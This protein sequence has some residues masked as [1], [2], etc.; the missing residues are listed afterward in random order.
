MKFIE[1]RRE[2][3]Q[4]LDFKR[5]NRGSPELLCY[6]ALDRDTK[7]AVRLR[8]LEEQGY[9][10][11]YTMAGIGRGGVNDC[12]IEHIQ[13]QSGGDGSDLEY[14][15][16]VICA[17]SGQNREDSEW[18]AVRKGGAAV[19]RTN[20][21]TPLERDCERRLNYGVSG[22]V[23][24][25]NQADAAAR[26]AIDLLAL[27]HRFLIDARK[28]AL[29]LQGL[30]PDARRPLTAARAERLAQSITQP[31]R[32]GCFSPYC[33]AIKQTAERYVLES[34]KRAARLKRSSDH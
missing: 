5:I 22:K 15:N 21:V 17:A 6:D 10:C 13:P 4:L 33:I 11:A 31:D 14:S 24:P 28:L 20:F 34:R 25:T 8:L 16:L 12:H 7:R 2:P 1:K 27:N 30:G 26:G 23:A 9:I 32:N 3:S 19:D 18:G 29:R